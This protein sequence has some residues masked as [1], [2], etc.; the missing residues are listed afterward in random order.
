MAEKIKLFLQE[1]RRELQRV[2]WPTRQETTKHT[3]IIIGISLVA[4][5]FLGALD[6]LFN[7][8]IEWILI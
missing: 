1:S 4:A 5:V 7:Y 2:N 8:A 3:M 6:F